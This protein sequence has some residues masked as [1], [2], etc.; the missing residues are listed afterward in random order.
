[1]SIDDQ[2]GVPPPAPDPA[3]ATLLR[4]NAGRIFGRMLRED[5]FD[6]P[7]IKAQNHRPLW[8][9]PTVGAVQE[10]LPEYEILSFVN[11]G[12]MGAIYKAVQRTLQRTVA[13][14]ILPPEAMADEDLNHAER[15][16]QAFGV[17]PG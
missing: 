5:D 7:D 2:P 4:E 10:L 8:Q 12:G 9:P 11:R 17:T 16:K 13:I 1:M 6:T 3:P 14:K 15:F